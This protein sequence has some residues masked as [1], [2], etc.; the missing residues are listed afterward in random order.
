MEKI[1]DVGERKAVLLAQRNVQAIVGSGG[2]QLKI[3]GTAESLPQRK[4]PGFIDP[5]SERCMYHQLH[6]AAF[7]KKALCDYRGLRRNS[8]K[9]RPAGD[10]VLQSLFSALVIQ[11]TFFFQPAHCCGHRSRPF[12]HFQR[13][14]TR[15]SADF[16][17][18]LRDVRRK[19]IR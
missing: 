1:K 7:V 8:S 6:S 2:L 13:T 15:E 14:G 11:S 5:R 16:L 10:Y 18:Q 17:A 9:R 19:F 3:K 12:T 4:S